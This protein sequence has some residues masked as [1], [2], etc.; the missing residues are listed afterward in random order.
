[1]TTDA[2]AP[3]RLIVHCPAPFG[4]LELRPL[5]P[6]KALEIVLA[7]LAA[8]V[9]VERLADG[10]TGSEDGA[11]RAVNALTDAMRHDGVAR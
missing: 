3:I 1:M 5:P 8:G 7:A 11:A 10:V 2:E 4:S 9:R 6:L